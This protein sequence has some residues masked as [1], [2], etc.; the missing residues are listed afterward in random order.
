MNPAD[1]SGAVVVWRIDLYIKEA[2]TQCTDTSFYKWNGIDT[3]PQ[4]QS[5]I[6]TTITDSISAR[7]LPASSCNLILDNPYCGH[8]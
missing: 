2:E 4:L 3:I 1:K 6:Q 7:H 8:F 5:S